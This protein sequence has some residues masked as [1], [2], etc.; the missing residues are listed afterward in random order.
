MVKEVMDKMVRI[1]EEGM[2]MIWVKKEMGFESKV[3]KRVILMD[4]GKIVEKN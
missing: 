1:D 3:E 4:K 2:K